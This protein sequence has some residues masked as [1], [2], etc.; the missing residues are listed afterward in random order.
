M[1]EKFSPI[2]P[3]PILKLIAEHN[4]DVRANKIDLGVGVYRDA[5]GVTPI[6]KVVKVAEEY[7]LNKQ[8]SKAYI[9]LAGDTAFNQ[10]MQDLVLDQSVTDDSHVTIQT[11]GG[12][13][14]LRVAIELMKRSSNKVSVWVSEPTWNN[15]IP[16]LE[17]VGIGIQ[18]YPY[19]D[20]KKNIIDFDAMMECLKRIPT[21]DVILLHACCHNPTGMD[22]T[23]EQWSEIAKIIAK[24]GIIPFIDNAYQG[25][26]NG[27]SEDAFAV[28]IMKENVSEMLISSSCSKNF[29]LYRDRSGT[30]TIISNNPK[31]NLSAR[32]HLLKI[33]RTM[34]SVPPDHGCAVVSHILN[35]I[36]L[37]KRWINE[38]SEVRNRLK[39]MRV[40]LSEALNARGDD[41]DSSHLI[42]ANGMFSYLG[43]TPEQVIELK[44]KHGI[45]MEGAGRINV[46]GI[47]EENVNLL[48]DAI[49]DVV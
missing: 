34:C 48:A 13:T 43:V 45:Y 23:H 27:L 28:K 31:N 7:L 4:N 30:L 44:I 10:A 29:G 25:L 37:R 6:M 5:S 36:E 49:I 8:K 21:G 15:H 17:S 3:D 16:I 24:R 47:T 9:G 33:V 32:S 38:L 42:R 39:S 1:F 22:P 35:N 12:S 14:S 41:F 11:A 2:P 20:D 19:Y 18:K 46:A 40:K 26:A